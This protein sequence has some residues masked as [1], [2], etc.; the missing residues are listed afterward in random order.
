[1]TPWGPILFVAIAVVGG[2]L[3]GARLTGRQGYGWAYAALVLAIASAI[4]GL[5]ATVA[6]V[7]SVVL[8]LTSVVIFI[9]TM[10]APTAP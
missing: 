10:R 6:Y 2:A 1:M 8:A 7:W 4:F 3:L 9:R 5:I